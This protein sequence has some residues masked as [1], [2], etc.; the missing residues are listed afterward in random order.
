MERSMVKG[1]RPMPTV[2]PILGNIVMEFVKGM[3][4]S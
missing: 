3:A 4:K 2:S 1:S